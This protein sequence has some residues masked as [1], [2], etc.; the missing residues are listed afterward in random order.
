MTKEAAMA[1]RDHMNRSGLR[2]YE[3]AYTPLK[4]HRRL[5]RRS[6]YYVCVVSPGLRKDTVFVKQ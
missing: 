3:V 6:P 1:M 4:Y 5:H 2:R